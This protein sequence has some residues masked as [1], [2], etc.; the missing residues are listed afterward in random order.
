[1]STVYIEKTNAINIDINSIYLIKSIKDISRGLLSVKELEFVNNKIAENKK[2]IYIN[3]LDNHLW[4]FLLDFETDNEEYVNIETTR[5][6]ANQIFIKCA[7]FDIDSLQIVDLVGN[8]EHTFAFLE[9][10]SLGAYSFDKY[11]KDSKKHIFLKLY[12][13]S[14]S[15]SHIDEL[16]CLIEAV[17]K[18]RDL[19]NEPHSYL[20]TT[21]F[22]EE[23]TQIAKESGLKLNILNK[24]KLAS[25]KMGGLLA[26]NRGSSEPPFMAVLEWKPKLAKNTKPI[27][28][29]GKG[30]TFDS[31]GYSIKTALGMEE[32]K[33]DMG[34]ASVVI[35]I[36]SLIAKNKLPV[37]VIGLIPATDNK[38]SSDAL[39]P[40]DIIT[41]HNGLT[42]EVLNTDAEGRLI[43]A[44][45]LSYAK[46]YAPELVIDLATLTGSA[47]LAIGKFGIFATAKNAKDSIKNLMKSGENVYER[48]IEFPLWDEYA[49]SIKSDVADVK[50]VGARHAGAIVAAKFLEKFIDYPWIHLD[51]AGPT[52]FSKTW[53]YHLSGA[54][55]IGVRLLY[56]FF[57]NYTPKQDM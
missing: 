3:R 38:I 36:L 51:I 10:I 42:V 39:T 30:I 15:V 46:N 2:S 43:L 52:Y 53:N 57:K 49:D 13:K 41:M 19:V 20:T 27:V 45:A 47:H 9:G 18:C 26:V 22:E 16:K 21:K 40:G 44:D 37:H 8:V 48:L 23:I 56:N 25:L 55:G 28:L 24:I 33:I 4:F 32:M 14:F 17:Y 54:T 29:V 50:N 35:S 34:G 5:R 12:S 31:G 7:G 11:K 1:M 6:A